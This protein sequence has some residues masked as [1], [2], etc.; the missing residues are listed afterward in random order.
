MHV[1]NTDH[2]EMYSQ[3]DSTDFSYDSPT[4]LAYI[5]D[6]DIS[7]ILY[8]DSPIPSA[9][10]LQI[11]TPTDGLDR[12]FVSSSHSINPKTSY[13]PILTRTQSTPELFLLNPQ[14]G[15]CT[16]EKSLSRKRHN[17]H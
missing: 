16:Y 3:A 13:S 10:N 11:F 17:Y 9:F 1:V 4:T 8:V 15:S 14:A 6:D 7:I 12:Y 5:L 2:A